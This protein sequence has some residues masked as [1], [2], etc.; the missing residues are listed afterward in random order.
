MAARKVGCED[1]CRGDAERLDHVSVGN[2]RDTICR[3]Q[4]FEATSGNAA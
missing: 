2:G 3:S 1:E 4:G